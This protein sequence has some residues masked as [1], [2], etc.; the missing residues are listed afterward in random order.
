[1]LMLDRDHLTAKVVELGPWFHQIDLGQG[2]RTRDIAPFP[3]PQ[4]LNHPLDR[5]L[6]LQKAIPEDLRGMRILDIG[7]AEGFFALE[8][9]RRGADVVAVDVSP[10]MIARLNWLI[11]HFGIRNITTRIATIESMHGSKERYDAILM[12]ALLYHLRHPLMGLDIAS[13]LTDTLYVESV[14]HVTNDDSYLYLRPP[15]EGVQNFPKW[16][17]TEKCVLD[18]FDFAGF[19]NST[20]LERP[21]RNRGLYIARR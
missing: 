8:L 4:P 18:M 17:P 1:M 19:K 16:I 3:G 10:K 15:I 11:E 5:W 9:A 13:Q 21:T 12:I 14:I 6:I 20:V 2:L 7:C